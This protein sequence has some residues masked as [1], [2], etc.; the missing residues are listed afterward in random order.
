MATVTVVGL[1]STFFTDTV[2]ADTLNELQNQQSQ[3]ESERSS[4]KEN[5]SKAEAEIADV[6]IDLEELNKEI[7]KNN[8]ALKTN[9]KTLNETTEEI[10]V[11]EEEIAELEQSIQKRSDILN[12]RMVSYQKNGGNIGFLDIIFGSKSFGDLVSRVSAVTKITESDSALLKQQEE[13]KTLVE[14]KLTELT[15]MKVELEGMQELI[16][17]QKEKNE[18]QKKQLKQK[19]QELQSKKEELKIKDSKLASIEAEVRRNIAAKRTP[20]ATASANSSNGSSDGNSSNLTTLSKKES[21]SST[22]VSGSG[23]LSTV[24]NAGYPYLGVPYVWA[25]KS[26]SG[27]DCSGFISWAFAQGGYSL[28]SSTAQLQYVGTK[29]SYSDVKP[30]DLVFFDT[31]KVNGHIGIYVGNGKFIGSQNSTGLAVADMTSGYWKSKFKGH[32]RR[33]VK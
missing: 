13:E 16:L 14:N 10:S 18:E 21:K 29:V 5:L 31:Y 11:K 30:G 19:E 22:P 26:P 24:I 12:D 28:P 2:H 4:I 25:G 20:P 33:V 6:L 15:D 9:E 23:N 17:V 1:G 7:T 32:V 27:F 8:E 3:I